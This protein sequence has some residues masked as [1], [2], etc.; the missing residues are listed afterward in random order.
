MLQVEALPPKERREGM[1]ELLRETARELREHGELLYFFAWRDVKI[2]YKQTVLGVLWA[3][4]QPLLT[5]L[6]F[7]IVFGR[8]ANIPTNGMPH[9]VFYFCALVPW[10]YLST[11][12]STGSAS[13]ISNADLLTKI[14]FPRI[15]LPGAVALGALMDFAVASVLIVGFVLYY[16]LPIGW[17]LLLWPLL[18]VPM[19]MLAT[20]VAMVLAT[21]NVRYRDLKYVVPFAIQLLFFVT[22]IIYPASMV[23][24]KFRWLL[25]VNPV[26]GLIEGF[27][28]AVMPD[29]TM[30]WDMLVVSLVVTAVLLLAAVLFFKRSER[31]F[32]DYV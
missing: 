10:T 21:L 1:A 2:R 25:M 19:V 20:S 22:P 27:R 23:P 30:H 4:L 6:I 24:D 16:G 14:Y 17:N 29:L 3:V 26:S 18:A 12:I 11:T 15:I 8:L 31:A 5:M 7:T 13:L 9:A 28:Y 32:A